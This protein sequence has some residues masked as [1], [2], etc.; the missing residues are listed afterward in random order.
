M[1]G[2]KHSS[3]GWLLFL[4]FLFSSFFTF[5]FLFFWGG[6]AGAG[7]GELLDFLKQ[8]QKFDVTFG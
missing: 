7:G 1:R 8:H 6:G 5:L 2:S 3:G 4:L